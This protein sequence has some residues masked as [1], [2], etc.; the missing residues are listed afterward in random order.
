MIRHLKKTAAA[1]TALLLISI[2]PW[3]VVEA[4]AANSKTEPE[5]SAPAIEQKGAFTPAGQA[6]GNNTPPVLKKHDPDAPPSRTIYYETAKAYT[7]KKISLDFQNADIHDIFKFISEASGKKIIVPD[8]VNG[9]ITLKLKDVPWDQVLDIALSSRALEVEEAGDVLTISER[10]TFVCYHAA[11]PKV[12]AEMMSLSPLTKKVFTPKH[13]PI[14]TMREEL[15]KLKSKRGRSVVIR[16][17]IYVEDEPEVIRAMTEVFIRNDYASEKVLLE[18]RIVE[19]SV[20]FAEQLGFKWLDRHSSEAEPPATDGATVQETSQE[21]VRLPDLT[22]CGSLNVVALKEADIQFLN[23]AVNDSN[24]AGQAQ[25]ISAPRFMAASGH[26]VSF[27]LFMPWHHGY[28]TGMRPA[29]P[30]YAR[31]MS[32]MLAA[33]KLAIV[34]RISAND[35]IIRLDIKLADEMVHNA[36]KYPLCLFEAKERLN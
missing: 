30:E 17:D 25:S 21:A 14:S 20:A 4:R 19:S 1:F 3:A 9:K 36:N 32:Y 6:S 24:S 13:I 16:N 2:L 8:F 28:H 10:A 31:D 27:N 35:G 11:P 22:D 7:G 34:P 15:D 29:L 23:A 18:V 5:S 12:A 26:E 33:L